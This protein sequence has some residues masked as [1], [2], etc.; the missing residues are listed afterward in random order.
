MLHLSILLLLA[1]DCFCNPT[2]IDSNSSSRPTPTDYDAIREIFLS[3]Q[4]N[5]SF[6]ADLKL[7]SNELHANKIIMDLKGKELENGFNNPGN[8]APANHI[9]NVLQQINDSKLFQIIKLMPKGGV[10][11]AHDT[12]L[13]STDKIIEF[14]YRENL[15]LLGDVDEITSKESPRFLFH[16]KKPD[17]VNGKEWISVRDIRF[18]KGNTEF[19]AQLRK[20]FSLYTN[21]PYNDYKDIN[22]VW[23][24]F[25]NIFKV[26]G[27]IICYDEVWKAYYYQALQ[28]FLDDGVQYLEFRGVLPKVSTAH[29]LNVFLKI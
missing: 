22:V 29:S 5:R 13:L 16:Y 23:K 12:A 10:L 11:H 17:P 7:N 2:I 19:D 6:G 25:M 28:E 4:F 14:T 3:E 1:S 9:F 8:F 27:G 15:W 20:L 18:Q 24:R 26:T 21:D